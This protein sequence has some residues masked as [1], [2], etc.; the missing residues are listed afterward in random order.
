MPTMR[1]VRPALDTVEALS[2]PWTPTGAGGQQIWSRIEASPFNHA[3]LGMD[4]GSITDTQ[5]MSPPLT[6]WRPIR[7]SSRSTIATAS[8]I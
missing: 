6:S 3:W 2:T 8:R 5:L 7:W 1:P 4:F